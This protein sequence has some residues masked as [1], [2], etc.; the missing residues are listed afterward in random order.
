MKRSDVSCFFCCWCRP[1]TSAPGARQPPASGRRCVIRVEFWSAN[2][3]PDPGTWKWHSRP[4][5][6]KSPLS[7]R[8]S[9]PFILCRRTA[10]M[11]CSRQT[12]RSVPSRYLIL[13]DLHCANPLSISLHTLYSN[14]YIYIC[15]ALLKLSAHLRH[16]KTTARFSLFT[17]ESGPS[18][19][20]S[21]PELPV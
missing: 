13:C 3:A 8:P 19:S 14:V 1:A 15:Q 18:H 7:G 6:D 5:S 9:R 4:F 20:P 12:I 10:P 2:P 21:R 17:T 16:N 11:Y